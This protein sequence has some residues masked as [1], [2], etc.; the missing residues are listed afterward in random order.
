MSHALLL[1]PLPVAVLLLA[2]EALAAREKLGD[3]EQ[4]SQSRPSD[5]READSQCRSNRCLPGPAIGG[6]PPA[7]YCVAPGMRCALPGRPGGKEDDTI[8]LAGT[9]YQC[10]DP[11]TGDP[12]RFAP[13]R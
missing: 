3:G 9:T 4:C 13:I 5:M 10:L 12:S 11:K 7:W 6:K 2:A 8:R 1:A